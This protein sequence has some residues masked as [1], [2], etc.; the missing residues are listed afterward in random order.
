MKVW[1]DEVN[2]FCDKEWQCFSHLIPNPNNDARFEVSPKRQELTQ[3]PVGHSDTQ[4]LK[5]MQSRQTFYGMD[6]AAVGSA[7]RSVP[8]N[9]PPKREPK[10]LTGRDV[11]VVIQMADGTEFTVNEFADD[12]AFEFG[13]KMPDWSQPAEVSIGFECHFEKDSKE[14]IGFQSMFHSRYAIDRD[15]L[16]ATIKEFSGP[17]L[18]GEQFDAHFAAVKQGVASVVGVAMADSLFP[19]ARM[20]GPDDIIDK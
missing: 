5:L 13:N 8:V 7:D 20:V 18:T 3:H 17:K 12:A 15:K 19:D 6:L 14:S 16:M 10:L 11:N 2:Q 9:W 4:M 1:I